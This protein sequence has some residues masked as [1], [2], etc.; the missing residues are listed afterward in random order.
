[1]RATVSE[2][3]EASHD[4]AFWSDAGRARSTLQRIYRLE[5]LLGR[6]DALRERA[7][8]LIE[9]ARRVRETQNRAR[10]AEIRNACA[11]MDDELLVLRLELAAAAAGGEGGDA[12]LRVVPVGHARPWAERLLAMYAAWAERTARTPLL[13]TTRWC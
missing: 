1:M 2:L 8:G 6:F 12:V 10:L 13:A 5:H 3:I 4:R 9:M 11:E 7:D